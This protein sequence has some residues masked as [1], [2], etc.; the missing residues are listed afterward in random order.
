MENEIRSQLVF[1]DYSL[2]YMR[3]ERNYKASPKKQKEIE[4]SFGFEVLPSENS[5]EG[6]VVLQCKIFD[7]SFSGG[8]APFF[9]ECA[10]RGNFDHRAG[11][12][13]DFAINSLA[14]LMPYLRAT[15]TSFT[16][17]AGIPAVII[18]PINVFNLFQQNQ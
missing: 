4:V 6:I 17:Q 1:K 11:E 10:I 12:F 9:L 3:F 2:D 14:I 13:E 15:I 7:E 16:A 5:N 18:P 8:K